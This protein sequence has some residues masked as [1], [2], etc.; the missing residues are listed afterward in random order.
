MEAGLRDSDAL[1]MVEPLG[2]GCK[3]YATQCLG[4]RLLGRCQCHRQ[5]WRM[6]INWE[7]PRGEERQLPV[8]FSTFGGC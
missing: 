2:I 1:V 3:Q 6:G 7:L 5:Q 8:Q 4:S